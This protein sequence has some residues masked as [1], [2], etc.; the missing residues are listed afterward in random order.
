MA[1][2]SVWIQFVEVNK[3]LAAANNCK[4]TKSNLIWFCSRKEIMD[5]GDEAEMFENNNN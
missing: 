1:W 2:L 4:E 5:K 3:L